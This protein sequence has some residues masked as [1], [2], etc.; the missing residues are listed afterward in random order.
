[1]LLAVARAC[2]GLLFVWGFVRYTSA[3]GLKFGRGVGVWTALISVT[4]FHLLFYATRTLPNTFALC[5]G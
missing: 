3:V 4:Q 1:M 2:L 5:I